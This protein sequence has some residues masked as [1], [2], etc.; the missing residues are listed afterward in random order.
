MQFRYAHK[1]PAAL[2]LIAALCAIAIGPVHAQNA[3]ES[4]TI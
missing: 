4:R 3:E 2:A 1:Y